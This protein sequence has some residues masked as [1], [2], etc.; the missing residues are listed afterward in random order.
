MANITT[1]KKGNETM[2]LGISEDRVNQLIDDKISAIPSGGRDDAAGTDSK[3]YNVTIIPSSPELKQPT[4]DVTTGILDLG[5]DPILIWK[6]G[7]DTLSS[8]AG[9][10]YR[11]IQCWE[12]TKSSA[13][14]FTYVPKSG[15]INVIPYQIA[16]P[17]NAL[18]LGSLKLKWNSDKTKVANITSIDFPCKVDIYN[19]DNSTQKL[20]LTKDDVKCYTTNRAVTT[21]MIPITG[22]NSVTIHGLTADWNYSINGYPNNNSVATTAVGP[23]HVYDSGWLPK[24]AIT[25]DWPVKVG[26]ANN[27]TIKYIQICFRKANNSV[28]TEQDLVSVIDSITLNTNGE[29]WT[30]YMAKEMDAVSRAVRNNT[31]STPASTPTPAV[32]ATP[33]PTP[34][35]VKYVTGFIATD[36]IKPNI[37]TKNLNIDFGTDGILY[38]GKNHYNLH[39]NYRNIPIYA[40]G[41]DTGATMVVYNTVNNTMK[42]MTWDYTP[43]ADEA[44]V[45]TFR[46]KYHTH[47]F[48]SCNF[49]FEITI[50]GKNPNIDPDAG[51]AKDYDVNVKSINHRG[52]FECPE[53]TISAYRGSAEH[54]FKYVETDVAFTSDDVPVLLHDKTINRTGK[55]PDG[56]PYATP[57]TE[58]KDI[59]FEEVRKLD[60][61]IVKDPKFKGEKIPSFEEFIKCCRNLGLHPYIELKADTQY[62]EAQVR[63]VVDIVNLNGMKGK[64]TYISFSDTDLMYVKN[65]DPKARLG[66]VGGKVVDE[67]M[68]NNLKALQ[69][70]TNE[71]FFDGLAF[72]NN[73]LYMTEDV[74]KKLVAIDVPLEVWTVDNEAD[75]LKLPSYV[76]G[77]TTNKLHAGKVLAKAE[78]NK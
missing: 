41:S 37:S 12:S 23:G 67:T 21:F 34:A 54:G 30:S 63:K 74:A 76:S 4:L 20:A 46:L 70:P 8:I 25:E 45:G 22:V 27:N 58:I 26:L 32:P 14:K 72:D 1:I 6:G 51:D 64:V 55:N 39:G 57:N 10:N 53:N 68:I 48:V 78:L 69:T 11:N 42:T 65:Y 47:E 15:V 7:F 16:I 18:L 61:G 9:S 31:S 33:T 19:P 56:S 43:T 52:W 35:E 60:F 75:V 5:V 59:T 13:I 24:G 49:P 40:N 66:R 73:V 17:N 38:I 36:P 50:D 2:Q 71:V 77:V 28:F 3:L 44:I 29:A 62:T